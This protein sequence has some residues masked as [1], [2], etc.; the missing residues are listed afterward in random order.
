M[1]A[2]SVPDAA[3]PQPRFEALWQ[4]CFPAGA[5]SDAEAAFE[6]L[7]VRYAEPH[8]CYHASA[9]IGHCLGEFD[10][11]VDAMEDA[12]AVEMALWFH[13]AVHDPRACDNEARS[14]A[15]F[16]ALATRPAQSGF[17]E[18]VG[19]LIL[20]TV[21]CE[22][23]RTTDQAFVVDIDLSSFAL[24]WPAF[25]RDSIAVRQEFAHLSDGDFYPKHLCFL[26]SL[27]ARP[28]VFFTPWFRGRC[29]AR[30]RGNIVRHIEDLRAQ[31]IGC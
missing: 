9:H 7:K 10:L 29:E 1:P 30:A 8:R 2:V 26:R 12:D 19:D 5:A 6:Q 16:A 11:A 13:D 17:T 3:L 20:M 27:L 23:P 18:R 24:P 14:A 22:Q 31:G 4:R 28:T 21:H 25:Q 15:L